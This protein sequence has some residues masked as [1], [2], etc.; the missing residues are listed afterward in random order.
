MAQVARVARV[1]R[2]ERVARVAH[3]VS[4]SKRMNTTIDRNIYMGVNSTHKHSPLHSA[5][6]SKFYSKKEDLELRF[7]G[8]RGRAQRCQALG[9]RSLGFRL[10]HGRVGS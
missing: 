6:I 7:R 8:P 9:F 5:R 2:V 1:A 4:I 10:G 3:N